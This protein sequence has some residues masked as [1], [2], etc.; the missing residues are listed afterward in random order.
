MQSPLRLHL[1]LQKIL[2]KFL[3]VSYWEETKM[4]KL[5]LV[6]LSLLVLCGCAPASEPTPAAPAEEAPFRAG[7]ACGGLPDG[8]G[9]AAGFFAAGG[10]SGAA[11]KRDRGDGE[12]H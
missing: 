1:F 3:L 2:I 4:K 7:G 6:L 8:A 5:L 12:P 9:E 10:R 11:G